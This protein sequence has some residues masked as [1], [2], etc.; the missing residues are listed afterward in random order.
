VLNGD[1]AEGGIGSQWMPSLSVST[2]GQ[3]QVSWYDRRNST[4]GM[5]YEYWGSAR[6]IT[7]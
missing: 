2:D 7:A 4:D 3:V 1:A 5:N 6:P